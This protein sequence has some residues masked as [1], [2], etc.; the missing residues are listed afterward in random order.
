MSRSGTAPETPATRVVVA[1]FGTIVAIAGMSHGYWELQQGNFVTEGMYINSVGPDQLKW[2]IGQEPAFTVLPT[3]MATG[4][5][6]ILVGLLASV[7]SI[8][9]VRWRHGP[10]VLVSLFIAQSLVG[11]GLGYIPFYLVVCAY[12]TRIGSPM[13]GLKRRLSPRLR[14][15][16]A[17]IWV[18]VTACTAFLFLFLLQ[19]ALHGFFWAAIGSE[20]LMSWILVALIVTM[21]LMNL[22]FAAAAASDIENQEKTEHRNWTLT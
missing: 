4:I 10:L 7:W 3:F 14:R 18:P 21:A 22:A 2:P 6:A 20:R 9:F 8:F 13:M 12:A 17:S 5:A 15:F 11:G 16:L 1:V 19:V